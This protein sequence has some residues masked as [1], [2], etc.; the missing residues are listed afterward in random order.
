MNT[1]SPEDLVSSIKS[2]VEAIGS[3]MRRGFPNKPPVHNPADLMHCLPAMTVL[4]YEA[5]IDGFLNILENVRRSAKGK[6]GEDFFDDIIGEELGSNQVSQS[7]SVLFRQIT[8]YVRLTT[9]PE[10]RICGL[11]VSNVHGTISEIHR[12]INDDYRAGLTAVYAFYQLYQMPMRPILVSCC[13][14][15]GIDPNSMEYFSTH[16][17]VAARIADALELLV[18][19]LEARTAEKPFDAYVIST[20]MRPMTELMYATFSIETSQAATA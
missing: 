2:Q 13:E 4:A 20:V 1:V 7:H 16:D 11:A 12:V 5:M 15:L 19:D 8:N 17:N 9:K 14:A 10:Q 3:T 18:L 6:A